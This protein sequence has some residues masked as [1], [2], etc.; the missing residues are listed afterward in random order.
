MTH[1]RIVI[2][3][4]ETEI[5]ANSKG[6]KALRKVLSK[7][8]VGIGIL[9]L[10]LSLITL[11]SFVNHQAH[12]GKESDLFSPLGRI[13]SVDGHAMS[14]YTEGGGGA[15]LVFLAGSGTASPILDFRS[16]YSQLSDHYEIVVVERL[17][18]GFSDIADEPRDVDTVLA[19]TREA[20]KAGG[21]AGP[22][23]L[24]PH[25]MAV[26]AALRWAQKYPGE[27][28]AI[29]GLDAA[30]PSVYEDTGPPNKAILQVTSLAARVGITRFFPSIVDDSAAIKAGSLSEREKDIYRA[31]FYRR[32][33]TRPMVKEL[34]SVV[35]NAETV[36]GLP[37]PQ[38]PMLFFTS[39]GDGTGL[40]PRAWQRHQTDYLAKVNGSQQITLDS[41]HYIQDF[42]YKAIAAQSRQFLDDLDIG[43][44]S[45]KGVLTT[46]DGDVADSVVREHGN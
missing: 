10:L 32:T 16:L 42:E 18:Y 22:Y 23:V 40:D 2:A 27:V 21:V 45:T 1:E 15:T 13:V 25:S 34:E 39:N 33:Q 29:I 24:F 17:G 44:G 19:E 43:T 41:G 30:V 11:S 20:L 6:S 38:L 5:M 4:T 35:K 9:S 7:T 3:L 46:L 28:S 37:P 14:L 8:G 36:G 12:L 26:L 31:V